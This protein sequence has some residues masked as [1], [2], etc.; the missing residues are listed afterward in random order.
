MITWILIII[1]II[2]RLLARPLYF[3]PLNLIILLVYIV[4][5]VTTL[6]KVKWS[7]FWVFGVSLGSI[8]AFFLFSE[9]ESYI[10][11]LDFILLILSLIAFFIE[12]KFKW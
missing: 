2:V 5:L 11:I 1:M 12:K 7:L 9:G 10:L 4:A 6:G 3:S 8:L